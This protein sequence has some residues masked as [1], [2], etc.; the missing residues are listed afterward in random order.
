MT[1]LAV[2]AS[3][4]LTLNWRRRGASLTHTHTSVCGWNRQGFSAACVTIQPPTSTSTLPR[5]PVSPALSAL[6][7][8]CISNGANSHSDVQTSE[9]PLVS[10]WRRTQAASFIVVFLNKLQLR[11]SRRLIDFTPEASLLLH[12]GCFF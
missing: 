1:K 7:G 5:T 10:E 2:D 4:F 9:L 3:A 12:K 8:I 6:G 11:S